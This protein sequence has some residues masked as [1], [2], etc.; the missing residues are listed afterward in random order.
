MIKVS[1]LFL[2]MG[3][4]TSCRQPIDIEVEKEKIKAQMNL[5]KHAHFAKDAVQ[6]YRPN[7]D[8]W[9]NVRHGNIQKSIKTDAIAGTQEYLDHMEFLELKERHV[10]LIEISDDGTLASYIGAVVVRGRLKKDPVFWVVS[11]QSVLKK[12][13]REWKIIS[14]ANTEAPK[15]A[16]APMILEKTKE[17]I[18]TLSD[19]STI[20]AMADCQGPERPFKTLMF[21]NKSGARMEQVYGTGHVLLKH[22]NN[23]SWTYDIM[24]QN[25]NDRPD[26]LTKLFVQ[27]HELHWLS[28]RPEDRFNDPTFI[29]F[30]EFKGETSFKIKFID[31][32]NRPVFFYYSFENYMPLGFETFTD[33]EN[34]TVR[35]HFIDWALQDGFKV[36][37]K[38]I[39]EQGDKIFS[40]D[41]TEIK[42]DRLDDEDF[43]SKTA[44]IK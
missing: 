41:F 38:A 44:Y 34:E 11:W 21:S 4:V 2:V 14:N 10:P 18:G 3:F 24:T 43:E 23:S 7:A 6:F 32:L 16:L 26:E 31:A 27:G 15:A 29:G 20:S 9:Y 1:V 19:S 33:K 39:F 40:Y 17:V 35:V 13:N 36:F 42:I 12:I 22:G 37:K 30:E 28:L 8:T 25:L 5:V